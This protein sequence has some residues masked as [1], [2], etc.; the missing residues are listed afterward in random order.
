MVEKAV[1]EPRER[2]RCTRGCI[3]VRASCSE[4]TFFGNP[5]PPLVSEKNLLCDFET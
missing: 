1:R 5:L 3:G 2:V 4:T